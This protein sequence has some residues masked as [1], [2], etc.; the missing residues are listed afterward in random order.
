MTRSGWIRPAL[1]FVARRLVAESVGLVFATRSRSDLVGLPELA[2]HRL[3][4][5]DARALLD[6]VL[7]VPLDE[8]VRDR[9]IA[10]ASGS[11]LALLEF[12][13][14]L[15]PAELAGGFGLPGVQPV[16]DGEKRR[17]SV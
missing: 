12:P 17:Q 15:S 14:G 5:R 4:P 3:R 7:S 2:V 8:Q 13:R 1:A 6:S 16:T 9:I 11:P 10:E